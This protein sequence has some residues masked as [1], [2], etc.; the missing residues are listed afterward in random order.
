M[1]TARNTTEVARNAPS[2]ATASSAHAAI[3][4]GR[5]PIRAANA[6]AGKSPINCPTPMSATINAAVPTLAPSS[7]AERATSGRIAPCP[8]ETRRVG[9]YAVMARLRR[10]ADSVFPLPPDGTWS[11]FP[12]DVL[13]RRRLLER[14]SVAMHEFPLI[15]LMAVDL[16]H[17]QIERHRLIF[18]AH[19]RLGPLEAN[20]VSNIA[21]G[22]RVERLECVHTAAGEER[23]ITFVAR[24]DFARA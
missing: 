22:R 20:P 4:A 16:G 1:A 15:V 14:V 6:P 12:P 19:V 21:T 3:K 2:R 13:R 5:S 7:R 18:A 24:P 10:R 17:S 9:P 11:P 8:T 23:R